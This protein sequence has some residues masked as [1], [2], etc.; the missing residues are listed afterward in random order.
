MPKFKG[1]AIIRGMN[2]LHLIAA[3]RALAALCLLAFLA[4]VIYFQLRDLQT[5]PEQTEPPH[6]E[7]E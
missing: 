5:P 3:L 6:T 4:S 1:A 2:E 7:G